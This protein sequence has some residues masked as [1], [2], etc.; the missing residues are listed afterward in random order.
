M[1]RSI[2][3]TDRPSTCRQRSLNR[4]TTVLRGC[5]SPRLIRRLQPAR[6]GRWSAL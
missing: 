3:W 6:S 4:S 5:R 1:N 2:R